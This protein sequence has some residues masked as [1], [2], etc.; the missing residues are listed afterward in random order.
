MAAFSHIALNVS[1]LSRSIEFYGRVLAPLSFTLADAAEGA[2]AR[3]TNGTSAVIVL[4]QVAS[5]RLERGYHRKAVG[6]AHLA[7]ATDS[8]AEFDGMREHL[9]VL[10]IPLLGGGLVEIEYRGRYD[11]FSFEDPDRIMIEVVHHPLLYFSA[12]PP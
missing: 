7:L 4:A 8:R 6:L 12:E 1:D 9:R 5:S 3:F 11:T 10:G 2:Y